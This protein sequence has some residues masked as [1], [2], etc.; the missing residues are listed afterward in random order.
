MQH[1]PER[2]CSPLPALMR[3]SSV[4]HYVK[5]GETK[6][7]KRKRWKQANGNG[8]KPPCVVEWSSLKEHQCDGAAVME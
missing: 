4:L 1:L 6:E 3:L 5:I 2:P 7:N 8:N